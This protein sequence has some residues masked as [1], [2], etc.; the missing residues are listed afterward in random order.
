MHFILRVFESLLTNLKLAL[1]D[2][3]SPLFLIIYAD[4]TQLSSFGTVKGYPVV[5]RIA[6]LPS[7]IRNSNG[8]GGGRLVG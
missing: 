7:N 8:A 4:K 3:A 1:P 2:H 6:N 5:A